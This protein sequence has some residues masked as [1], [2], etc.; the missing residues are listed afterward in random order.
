MLLRISITILLCLPLT[1]IS[2]EAL[3][4]KLLQLFQNAESPEEQCQ[5]LEEFHISDREATDKIIKTYADSSL[6]QSL[7]CS[8][9]IIGRT[10]YLTAKSLSEKGLYNDAIKTAKTALEYFN[11]SP[12]NNIHNRADCWLLIGYI[13]RYKGDYSQSMI[14]LQEAIK[15]YKEID[16]KK[17]IAGAYLNIGTVQH[18][19][20]EYEEA[21]KSYERSDAIYTELNM[22]YIKEYIHNNIGSI[23]LEEKRYEE[24]IEQFIIGL[25]YAEKNDNQVMV[26]TILTNQAYAYFESENLEDANDVA[27]RAEALSRKEGNIRMLNYIRILKSKI[28]LAKDNTIIEIDTLLS[29]MEFATSVDDKNL[30]LTSLEALHSTYEREED[31]TNS[32][33]YLKLYQ[34]YNDSIKSEEI[35]RKTS[36]LAAK[37]ELEN[38]DKAM[39]MNKLKSTALKRLQLTVI[40]LLS[41]LLLTLAYFL[42]KQYNKNKLLEDSNSQLINAEN[43]VRQQRLDLISINNQLTEYIETNIQLEHF[44]YNV[45]HDLKSPLRTISSFSSLLSKRLDQKLDVREKEYISYITKGV[46]RMYH[47]IDDLLKLSE[48]K[49][50]KLNVEQIDA[51]KFVR[52]VINDVSYSNDYMEI[53]IEHLPKV[54]YTDRIKL[55]RVFQ[56]L[57]ENAIKYR[58]N[59]VDS[60]I[61]ISSRQVNGHI[62]FSI[63]DNGI[64]IAPGN[65]ESVFT[66]FNRIDQENS[67]NGSG[68]G[69]SICKN[70]V[71]ILGGKIWVKSILGVGSNFLFTIPNLATL[72]KLENTDK[73]FSEHNLTEQQ[74][75][76]SYVD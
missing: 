69:L 36:N 42:R 31:Y 17:G 70:L 60:M 51:N 50:V 62:E 73:V 68:L 25:P 1:L 32:Y 56:N 7:V 57:I 44:A 33:K 54:I 12:T 66:A 72:K 19:I 21:I 55:R 26:S 24:A 40:S 63:Q 5:I 18:E 34:V 47:L 38:L 75:E 74:A 52:D 14:D 46:K 6:L 61:K 2:A 30:L 43:E 45:S 71:E 76:P 29:I 8:K 64:G 22:E 10:K 20:Y 53:R 15:L 28:G 37:Y 16:Y 27:L 9:T 35:A 48:T 39:E 13:Q 65:L 23:Y 67:I 59:A 58:N 41:L 4:D 11:I 49:S 3:D